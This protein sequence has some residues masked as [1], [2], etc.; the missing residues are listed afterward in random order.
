M[1]LTSKSFSALLYA[2]MGA[3]EKCLLSLIEAGA[4]VNLIPD[5]GMTPLAE[6]AHWGHE[7]CVRDLL[8]ERADVN[9]CV[10]LLIESGADVNQ[11]VEKDSR[12]YFTL[13]LKVTETL[14]NW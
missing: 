7:T 10:N 6:A 12:L 4:D 2:A 1:N 3:H 9:K 13:L 14:Q 11:K 8:K 5:R